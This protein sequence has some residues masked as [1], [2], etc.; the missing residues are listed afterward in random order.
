MGEY[1]FIWPAEAY[2]QGYWKK[3]PGPYFAYR[4]GSGRDRRLSELWGAAAVK[5]HGH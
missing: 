3:N 5:P 1:L 4:A 2:H